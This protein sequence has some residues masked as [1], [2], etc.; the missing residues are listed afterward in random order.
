ML[1]DF[2]RVNEFIRR[3]FQR[4]QLGGNIPQPFWEYAHTHPYFNHNLTHR[5][6][7][8]EDNGEIAAV[9][10]YE[11]DLGECYFLTKTGYEYMKP[12]MIDYAEKELSKVANHQ[13]SLD[14]YV[15]DYEDQLKK[16]L[17]QKGYGKDWSAPITVFKYE[18]GFH[19]RVL[20]E[21]FS[22]ITLED[23]NDFRKI[24]DV[25]WRG[26]DHEDEPDDDLDCRML[27]QSAPHFRK[28][29]TT[30]IKAPNG[31]YACFAGMWMDEVND[32]AYIEP[33]VTDPRYRRMGLATI[34]ITESMKHTHKF[35]A[36]YCFGGAPEFY[37]SIGFETV[38]YREKWSKVW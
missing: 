20:P 35:G 29:L 9:A 22:I 16:A 12:G 21:G 14:I 31:E 26:F 17:L 7:I 23:E 1:S 32:F 27:M 25:L 36:T 34:A 33:L 10:C 38:C 28:D 11:L 24:H 2:E 19:E 5:F 4:Y 18:N 30:I 3:N 13:K 37:T 6:G 15:F 8:W